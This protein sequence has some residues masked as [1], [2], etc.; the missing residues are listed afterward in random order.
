[1]RLAN[2]LL[3]APAACAPPTVARGAALE[4]RGSGTVALTMRYLR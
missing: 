1:M 3:H 2:L 4:L